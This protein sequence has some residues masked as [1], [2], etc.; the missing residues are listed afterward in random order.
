[1]MI[2][3]INIY[4]KRIQRMITKRI[5][6]ILL[7]AASISSTGLLHANYDEA[8]FEELYKEMML[9][10]DLA[11][12]S[13]EGS[14]TA[15]ANPFNTQTTS[16]SPVSFNPGLQMKILLDNC[17]IPSHDQ[18]PSHLDST[19]WSALQIVRGTNRP[20]DSL[21]NRLTKIDAQNDAS[22]G[23]FTL[24]GKKRF[25]EIL[26]MPSTNVQKLQA[27]QNC[28]RAIQKNSSWHDA[29]IDQLEIMKENEQYYIDFCTKNSIEQ[30]GLK[31]IMPWIASGNAINTLKR[32]NAAFYGLGAAS[33]LFFF[34]HSIKAYNNR[35]SSENSLRH[36]L[37]CAA[38]GSIMGT[39]YYHKKNTSYFEVMNNNVQHVAQYINAQR[40]ILNLFSQ[41]PALYQNMPEYKIALD[42]LD[43]KDVNSSA[44]FKQLN[45]YFANNSNNN[46]WAET[47]IIYKYLCTPEIRKEFSYVFDIIGEID[48][49]VALAS[50]MNA[51]K[52]TPNAQFCFV[53]FIKKSTKPILNVKNFWNP[54][55]KTADAVANSVL[56]NAGSERSMIITGPNTGGKSTTMKGLIISILTAQAFGIAPAEK[57]M[58][59]PFTNILTYL[60]I[61]DD[62]G[63]GKSKFRAELDRAEKLMFSLK[64]LPAH[65]FGFV[66]LDEIFTGTG[67]EQGEEFACKFIKSI[68]ANQNV[69][70]VSATHLEKLKGLE[71][72][73]DGCIKNYQ[74]DVHVD[75]A[76]RISKYTYQ[77]VPGASTVN[78]VLQVAREAGISF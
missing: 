59:T 61:G 5:L 66:I 56:L 11:M 29:L 8:C 20:E 65:D 48:S 2:Y 27:R 34:I 40:A 33:T 51:H 62:T 69:I 44:E 22:Q 21:V 13:M 16:N 57:M 47:F 32:E 53:D 78:S 6:S 73:T 63:A 45:E 36:L 43:G 18:E 9:G 54:F 71:K 15:G 50:K 19:T 35:Y 58:F 25:S 60:N 68:H 3:F 26:A 64:S 70:F 1:M 74:M 77:I 23:I 38:I 4:S 24:I 17:F 37:P 75:G 12:P 42:I 39:Y 72:E 67:S 7:L 76:G 10:Y 31:T 52:D 30:A 41:L 49:Y 46:S 55:I 14:R 28:I